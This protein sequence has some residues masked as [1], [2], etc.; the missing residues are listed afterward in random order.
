MLV[1]LIREKGE[2][3]VNK[4]KAKELI[5]IRFVIRLKSLLKAKRFLKL[6]SEASD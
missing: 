2:L 6:D 1:K 5:Q 4:V 3:L